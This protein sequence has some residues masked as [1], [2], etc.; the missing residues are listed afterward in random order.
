M[1]VISIE[2]TQPNYVSL[3]LMCYCIKIEI[4]EKNISPRAIIRQAA[5]KV[6]AFSGNYAINFVIVSANFPPKLS[7]V[8]NRLAQTAVSKMH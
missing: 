7:F 6:M 4:N 3:N 5:V 1:I 8:T 2:Q